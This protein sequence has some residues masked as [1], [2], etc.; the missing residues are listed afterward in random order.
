MIKRKSDFHFLFFFQFCFVFIYPCPSRACIEQKF[1]CYTDYGNPALI[2][3][4][5]LYEEAIF[6]VGISVK[7]V[8]QWGV[9]GYNNIVRSKLFDTSIK[10]GNYYIYIYRER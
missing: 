1:P 9:T 4:Y 5:P 3:F 2:K 6:E 8:S 7:E 10:P